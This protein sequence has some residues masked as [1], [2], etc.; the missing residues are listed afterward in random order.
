MFEKVKTWYEK[1]LWNK[2]NVYDAVPRFI[3]AE[4]YELL[5]GEPYIEGQGLANSQDY[6]NALGDLGV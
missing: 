4:E 3:T 2:E 6:Q 1:G 5:V